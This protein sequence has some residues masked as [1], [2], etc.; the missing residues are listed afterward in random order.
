MLL[1]EVSLESS[2]TFFY[3]GFIY[4]KNYHHCEKVTKRS[5][6]HRKELENCSEVQRK[7]ESWSDFEEG[8]VRGRKNTF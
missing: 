5:E 1:G 6:R 3:A 8:R 4:L 2:D 7:K